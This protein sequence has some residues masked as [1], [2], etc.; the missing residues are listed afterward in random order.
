M[1]KKLLLIA[2][3]LLLSLLAFGCNSS[4]SESEDDTNVSTNE[5]IKIESKDE[6]SFTDIDTLFDN[7]GY[8][9]SKETKESSLVGAEEGYIY[10]LENGDDYEVYRYELD[11]TIYT[12]AYENSKLTVEGFDMTLDVTF[13]KNMALYSYPENIDS[14]NII[15]LFNEL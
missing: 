11:T 10:K 7:S 13:N 2:T 14:N 8:S 1:K 3:I 12:E 4:E 6:Y 5:E 15:N 9:Y